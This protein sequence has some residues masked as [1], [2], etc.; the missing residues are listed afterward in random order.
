MLYLPRHSKPRTEIAQGMTPSSQLLDDERHLLARASAGDAAAF[1][2]LHARFAVPLY[3]Q[4]LLPKLGDHDAAED[5]LA[6]T[7]NTLL[8]KLSELTISDRSLWYWLAQV[9]RN[10]ATDAQRKRSR[11]E[12]VLGGFERMMQVVSDANACRGP[13]YL[14]DRLALE[15]SVRRCL[16]GL[17]PRYAHAIRLRFFE[18]RPRQE[19]AAELDVKLGTFDVVLL[20]A[21][22][23]FRRAWDECDGTGRP[24]PQTGGVS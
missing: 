6:D 9:A 16:A 19:C 18:A 17:R 1:E 8:A 5:V 2:G 7:F 21:L 3:Q 15:Q 14:V 24:Q 20:R 22:K 13:G 23:A 12:Q 11:Q 4:V 10:K